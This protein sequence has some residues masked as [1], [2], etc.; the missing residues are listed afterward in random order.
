MAAGTGTQAAPTPVQAKGQVLSADQVTFATTLAKQTGLDP[1]VIAAWVLQEGGSVTGGKF[2]FLNIGNTDSGA[3]NHAAVWNTNPTSAAIVTAQWLKG[4]STAGYEPASAGIRGILA[5][6]GKAPEAQIKAIQGSG[7]A[8][9]GEPELGAF[10]DRVLSTGG[11]AH[12]NTNPAA[13]SSATGLPD[14]G[15][16]L[17]AVTDPLKAAEGDFS[18][19]VGDVTS[20]NLWIRLAQVLG[21]GILI[22]IGVVQLAG[23]R[24]PG[25]IGRLA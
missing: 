2:N 7:W 13:D 6:A 19:F 10:W 24:A 17:N 15:N 1:N 25:P 16:P 9:S 23:G 12:P 4:T 20:A 5:A 3:R 8:T 14:V 21:G 18:T 11:V 22:M